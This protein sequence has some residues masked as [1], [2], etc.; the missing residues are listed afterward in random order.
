MQELFE[1]KNI[2]AKAP[3][4]AIALICLYVILVLWRTS[5]EDKKEELAARERIQDKSIAAQSSQADA[6]NELAQ[7]VVVLG[8]TN[9][10]LA[11]IIKEGFLDVKIVIKDAEERIVKHV[12]EKNERT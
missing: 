3:I 12:K 4:V 10:A 11:E 5:R 8:E 6:V 9:K 2:L 7:S 1:I